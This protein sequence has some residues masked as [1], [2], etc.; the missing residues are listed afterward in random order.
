M[1]VEANNLDGKTKEEPSI[2]STEDQETEQLEDRRRIEI[3]KEGKQVRERESRVYK[4]EQNCE[5]EVQTKIT[6]ET[7]RSCWNYTSKW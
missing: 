7:N 5:K 2:L 4:A 6:K 3:E 1:K